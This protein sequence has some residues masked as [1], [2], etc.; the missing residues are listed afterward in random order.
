MTKVI[1]KVTKV[2]LD[3]DFRLLTLTS[4]SSTLPWENE[5]PACLS[6]SSH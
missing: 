4:S 5:E 3:G 6:S 1:W 2:M